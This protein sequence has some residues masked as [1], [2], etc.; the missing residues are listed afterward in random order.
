MIILAVFLSV[1]TSSSSLY[2]VVTAAADPQVPCFF[3]FGDSLNDC[4]NNNDADTKAKANYKPYGIDYPDGPTGRFTN[5]RTAV[6][7]LAEHLGFGNPIPPFTTAKGDSIL[8][9]INYASGSAG[10]LDETGKHLG[11]NVPLGTQVQNHQKTFSKI[12]AMKGGKDSAT[13][14]LN[15]C[16]Y[17]MSIGSNDFLNNYFL[18]KQYKTS[19]LYSVDKFT[20]H[21]ATTYRDK[22]KTL[23]HYGA[24]KI[25]VVGVGKVGCVPHMMDM[26]GTKGS[27]CIQNVNSAAQNF[28][29][30][31]KKLVVD[32]N[33]ELKDAKLIYINSYG[34][35]DGDPTIL[36]FKYITSGCCKSRE[37]GQCVEGETPCSNRKEYVFWDSFHPTETGHKAVADRTYKSLLP[38]DSDPFDLHSLAALDIGVKSGRRAEE[39]SER[40][41]EL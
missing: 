9:G 1:I 24:R 27:K 36:G 17:Y 8:Q 14:H 32:L 33:K 18:P 10:I 13:K 16:I 38:S 37:D 25:A 6:D 12:A 4:G 34:M 35:S 20:V 5:G 31:L 2:E 29:K 41:L 21:L 3:I 30:Q 15:G 40:G 11:K 7:F 23:H 28:N 26:F 19:K 22:I 39:T